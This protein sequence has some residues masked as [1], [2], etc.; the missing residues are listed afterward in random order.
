MRA[1]KEALSRDS[2][3][4]AP[5]ARRARQ[6]EQVFAICDRHCTANFDGTFRRLVNTGSLLVRDGRV[7]VGTKVGTKLAARGPCW[8]GVGRHL[9]ARREDQNAG[10]ERSIVEG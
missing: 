10:T 1:P 8:L 6:C 9:F 3:C 7:S 5:R 2:A 4:S